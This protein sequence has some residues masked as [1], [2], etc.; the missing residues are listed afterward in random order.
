MTGQYPDLILGIAESIQDYQVV[1]NI[2]INGN[3][4]L[5]M[6]NNDRPIES[7]Q[8]KLNFGVRKSAD[9]TIEVAEDKANPN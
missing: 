7:K 9:N 4:E 3:S 8:S 1:K 2:K 6:D 5:R